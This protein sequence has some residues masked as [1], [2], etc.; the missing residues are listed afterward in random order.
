MTQSLI[1]AG[2]SLSECMMLCNYMDVISEINSIFKTSTSLNRHCIYPVTAREPRG[3]ISSDKGKL[4]P[5]GLLI[6]G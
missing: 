3:L 2:M 1:P 4:F 6:Q 5:P